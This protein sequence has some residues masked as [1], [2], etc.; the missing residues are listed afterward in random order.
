MPQEKI[1]RKN[2]ILGEVRD[3]ILL[4]LVGFAMTWFG[5]SCRNCR[6]DPRMFMIMAS[7]TSLLWII[8][9]KGNEYLT[10]YISTRISWVAFPVKRFLIGFIS[11]VVYTFL[12]MYLVTVAYERSFDISLPSGV[13]VSV[14]ITIF[15]S[16]FMHAKAFLHNWRKAAIEAEKYQQESMAARYESLKNQVNPHFLFNSLNAL[17][18]L[19]YED[20]NK[21]AMFIDELAGVYRY[22]LET[23]DKDVVPV[24]EEIKFLRSYLYLQQIRFG[25]KLKIDF[26]LDG[27]DTWVPPLSLQMLI[28]NAIKHNI[29]SEE[30][31]L[32][33][34]ISINKDF[35]VVE[36]NL[37]RKTPSGDES[38]GMGLENIRRRYDMLGGKK[39]VV[40]E[41]FGVFSV[42][43]PLLKNKN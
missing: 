30:D 6:D 4:I 43:L 40:R 28:E 2:K 35:I 17:S 26:L 7:F 9:W 25:E 20:E 13:L 39:V 22:V 42:M 29:I 10:E 31:P 1:K 36:N 23:Q 41:E 16:L 3:F 27:A 5:L 24:A 32:G 18:N 21:A 37:Q 33:I 11:T 19:V 34:R 8:L 15:I 12:A 38:S 14:L